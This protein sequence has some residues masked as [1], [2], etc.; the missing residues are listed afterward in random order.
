[1][2]FLWRV[3]TTALAK[4]PYRTQILTSGMLWFGGDVLAQTISTRAGAAPLDTRRAGLNG[5]YGGVVNGI[6]GHVWYRELDRMARR[7]FR[8]GSVGFVAAKVAADGI[9]FGPVHVAV[10]GMQSPWV[11]ITQSVTQSLAHSV[12]RLYG[13]PG[14]SRGDVV[15][16]REEC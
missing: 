2:S 12:S 15:D 11:T 1:M 10:R 13:Y 4:H 16:V 8:S 6:L 7:H 14:V 3:Y 5:G 9:I